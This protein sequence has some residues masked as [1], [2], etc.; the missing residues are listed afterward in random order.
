V[1]IIVAVFLAGMSSSLMAEIPLELISLLISSLPIIGISIYDDIKGASVKARL[2]CQAVG[3]LTFSLW[4]QPLERL[5]LPWGV[6]ALGG[7]GHLLSVLWLM[8]IANAF[9]FLDGLDGLAAGIAAISSLA[10]FGS[11]LIARSF[12]ASVLAL[13][14]VGASLGFLPYNFHPARIFMGDTGSVFLGFVLGAIALVG[15][16]KSVALVSLGLPILALGIPILDAISAVIRR[17]HHGRSIFQGDRAHIHHRLLSMGI[18]HSRVVIYL[19]LISAL[20]GLLGL[21]LFYENRAIPILILLLGLV[22]GYIFLR[23]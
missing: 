1:S 23:R 2:A 4:V 17:T 21:S 3:G 9:N 22:V 10:L 12:V 7:F 15:A 16:G 14:V 5:T 6:V 11:A 18:P 20:L 8:L 13:V 19:Y